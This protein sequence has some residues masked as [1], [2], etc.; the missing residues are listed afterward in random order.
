[1]VVATEIPRS[2]LSNAVEGVHE[3]ALKR[4]QLLSAQ[5]ALGVV[6][7]IEEASDDMLRVLL[8]AARDTDPQRGS[9]DEARAGGAELTGTK[10]ARVAPRK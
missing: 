3:G 6:Q 4:R 10:L 2:T 8:R 9:A 1:M 7:L 5:G